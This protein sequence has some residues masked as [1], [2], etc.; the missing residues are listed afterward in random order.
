VYIDMVADAFDARHVELLGQA[1]AQGDELVVGLHSDDD[2]EWFHRRPALGLDQ[3]SHNVA[4]CRHVDRV[5][6]AAPAFITHAW[7]R[8]QGI[9]LVVHSKGLPERALRY[10]Y[11]APIEL[12]IFRTLRCTAGVS[13]TDLEGR[14]CVREMPAPRQA[15]PGTIARRQLQRWLPGADRMVQRRALVG[16]LRRLAD[17][18]RGTPLDERYWM[19]GGLL[20]GWAREGRPL[21]SDLQDADLA[22]LDED[23]D[24]F[25]ASIPALVNAG[26]KPRH[27]FSSADGRYVEHRFRRRNVQFDFFRM[28]PVRARWRYSMFESGD[29]PTE[30][31]AEVPAQPHVSFRSL[32]RD[33]RKVLDHDLALRW[34][35]GDWRMDRPQWSFTSDRA[36]VERIPMAFLPYGWAWP[37]AIARGPGERRDDGVRPPGQDQPGRARDDAARG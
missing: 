3:R 14:P 34:I 35:Y 25:L 12:G 33:W 4:A 29:E 22:Y 8:A 31:V 17:G 9:D 32:G 2:C 36:I 10:W 13:T 20:L 26:L 5:I 6:A 24:R 21:A 28:T 37:D 16:G 15:S 18:L 7:L 30:L 11:G 23:H 19:V 1:R 27:R